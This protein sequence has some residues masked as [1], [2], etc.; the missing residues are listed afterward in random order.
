MRILLFDLDETLLNS[1]KKISEMTYE[2]L[3]KCRDKGILIGVSTSRSE[4]NSSKYINK[5][6][7][8]MTISSGGAM[9]RK[10]NECIFKSE[11][12]AEETADLVTLA[13]K[14][15][16]DCEITADILQGHYWNYRTEPS[17]LDPEWGGTIY[18]LSEL[19]PAGIENV[20]GN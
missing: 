1:R 8:D 9:I 6:Q 15:C 11:F 16:G 20:R 3:M 12:T 18:R 5:L 4:Q 19:F 17:L 14:V 2:S 10:G 7:P 13:R